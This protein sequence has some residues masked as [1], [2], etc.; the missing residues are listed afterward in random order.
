MVKKTLGY[1]ELEWTCTQCGTR[2][3]GGKKMCA[4]CGAP[5]PE[6]VAFHQAAEEKLLTDEDEIAHAKAGPDVHCAFCGARNRADA[7]ECTQCG[8]DLTSATARESGRVLGAFR[9][10]PAQPVNCPNCGTPN[11]ANAY[12]CSQCGARL[13][14]TKR[15]KPASPKTA[16]SE[17]ARP[18]RKGLRV[19]LI[20][21][22]AFALLACVILF[23][24]LLPRTPAQEVTG[25]VQGLSWSRSIEIEGLHEVSHEAW[26]DSIPSDAQLGRCTQKVHHTQDDPAPG[27]KE[28]CG[29]P[30]VVDTGTGHGEVVQDC[31]Y[32]VYADWC[33]YTTQEWAKV[34]VVTVE[35]DATSPR[36]PDPI[37]NAQ[38]RLGDRDESY[39]VYFDTG[40]EVVTYRTSDPDAFN[41]YPIGSTWLLR[42]NARGAA[43][44]I[45]PA[46]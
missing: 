23:A 27:A 32:E 45:E 40:Q 11:P 41:Q 43:S 25:T 20:A 15:P 12:K 42:V 5:Q 33:T 16:S 8:A 38:Q 35:G 18:Q 44:P 30:Y 46:P 36:W 37:L 29:T 3:P 1:V 14:R 24:I 17:K 19:G 13:P 2:N 7:K 4:S 22:G 28:V 39:Q 21:G 6:K 9:D 26:R 34:D 31:Q 10:R